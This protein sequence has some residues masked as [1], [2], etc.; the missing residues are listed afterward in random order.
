MSSMGIFVEFEEDHASFEKIHGQDP[1]LMWE[2]MRGDP[3]VQ[4]LADFAILCLGVAVNQAG[5]KRDFSDFKI[6]KTR[7]CNH[8]TFKKTEKISKVS[9]TIRAEH[10]A[11]SF[12]NPCEKRKN[13]DDTQVAGLIVVL[14]YANIIE[15]NDKSKDEVISSCGLVNSQSAWRKLHVKWRLTRSRLKWGWRWTMSQDPLT[16]LSPPAVPAE[17]S[18]EEP[19]DGEL[20]G[21]GDDFIEGD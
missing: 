4:E 21:S 16:L 12:I 6:K 11:T 9:A 10:T 1:I 18:K 7:L 14:Q 19:D 15:N 13:H 8:L 2:N 5:N 17:H 3:D 20:E